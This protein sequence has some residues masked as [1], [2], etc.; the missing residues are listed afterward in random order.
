M[1]CVPY[2]DDFLGL[3]PLLHHAQLGPAVPLVVSDVDGN[4]RGLQ[5]LVAVA[6]TAAPLVDF[7][8]GQSVG[9]CMSMST[10]SIMHSL[11]AL[12]VRR[13]RTM[14]KNIKGQLVQEGKNTF[15]FCCWSF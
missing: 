12:C 14:N 1:I 8:Q 6:L 11:E 9:R 15:L 5:P 4:L 10:N 7:L 3:V 2:L 13:Y